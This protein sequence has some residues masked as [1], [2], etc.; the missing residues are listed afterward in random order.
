MSERRYA[1]SLAQRP[2]F[3]QDS[4]AHCDGGDEMS[5][6]SVP[7]FTLHSPSPRSMSVSLQ[8]DPR[9]P[10]QEH[11]CGDAFYLPLKQQCQHSRPRLAA[12]AGP[13]RHRR[14]T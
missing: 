14:K 11:G 1:R 3:R 6:V 7:S 4:F 12:M 10:F 13:V 8:S 9:H 5:E 2:L